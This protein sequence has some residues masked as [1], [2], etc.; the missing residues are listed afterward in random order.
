MRIAP[1]I[2]MGVLITYALLCYQ[3]VY[4]LQ[5]G[6]AM[7]RA[8][9][10]M[11]PESNAERLERL[12]LFIAE[13]RKLSERRMFKEDLPR[14]VSV[15]QEFHKTG[16]VITTEF[17]DEEDFRSTLM[18]LRLF[19]QNNEPIHFY[20][21]CNMLYQMS[22]DD[23]LKGRV[24]FIRQEY[25]RALDCCPIRLIVPESRGGPPVEVSGKDLIDMYFY[26]RYFHTADKHEEKRLRLEQLEH[27]VQP[28]MLKFNLIMAVKTIARCVFALQDVAERAIECENDEVDT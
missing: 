16:E 5:E 8:E 26:T 11:M 3:R 15:H 6:D 18:S 25:K 22:I 14:V 12:R 19:Y 20:S 28:E 17:P 10:A 1:G 24:A 21:V 9:S 7:T 2:D 27:N 4:S 13:A 23:R